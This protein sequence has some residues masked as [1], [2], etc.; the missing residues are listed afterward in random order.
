MT[1]DLTSFVRIGCIRAAAEVQPQLGDAGTRFDVRRRIGAEATAVVVI[2][3]V[4]GLGERTGNWLA[5]LY[6]T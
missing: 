1:F 6:T 2:L 4:K 3:E 5:R